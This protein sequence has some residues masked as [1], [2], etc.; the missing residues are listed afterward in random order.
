MS[1]ERFPAV[2]ASPGPSAPKAEWREWAFATRRQLPDRSAEVTFRLRELLHE[3]A[4][5]RVLAYRALPGEPDVA[6]LEDEF[7]LYTT[8]TRYRPEKHLTLHP[9]A[10]ATEPTRFGYLQPPADA[11]QVPLSWMD[12]VLLPGLAFDRQ[13]VRL[14]YGG[15]FY[16][17][18]LAGYGGPCVGMVWHRLLV[19]GLPAEPHDIRAGWVVTEEMTVQAL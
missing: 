8:R 19:P 2:R 7:E 4:V 18:L 14:G 15:G 10:S 9:W 12:A 1:A 6:A 16:D 3:N 13:G 11:P 5:R 17:R